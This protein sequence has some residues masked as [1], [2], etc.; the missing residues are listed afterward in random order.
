MEGSLQTDRSYLIR[1]Q[2]HGAAVQD[3]AED[4][5]Y[6]TTLVIADG[7]ALTLFGSASKS[8]EVYSHGAGWAAPIP[9]PVS[10]YQHEYY[11]WTYLLPD[12]R[13]FIAGP[14]VPTQRFNWSAPAAIDSFPTIGGN[15]SSG[16]EKGTSVMLILRPPDYKPIVYIMGGDC[17]AHRK[18]PNKLIFS[19]R[20]HLE[21][22]FLIL[23]PVRAF[24]FTA[25]LLPDG[26]VFIAGGI[27]GGADGGPCE[28]FDPRE[29][30]SGWQVGP[31][32]KYVRGYHS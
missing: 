23:V 14:H 20:S 25:I 6:S 11:P 16:G 19:S 3:T 4:R 24:Q 1:L 2:S 7:R 29:P 26:R 27:A 30:A 21:C 17:L 32:M 10:M 15:R 12:G 13:L 22:H 31:S 28:I 9:M 18:L 8:I 5:F